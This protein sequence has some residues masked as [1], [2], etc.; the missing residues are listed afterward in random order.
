MVSTLI[1]LKYL[2]QSLVQPFHTWVAQRFVPKHF[3]HKDQAL[4]V[5]DLLEEPLKSLKATFP[6][7]EAHSCD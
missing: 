2:R 5:F 7:V 1:S 4:I 6:S 3:L